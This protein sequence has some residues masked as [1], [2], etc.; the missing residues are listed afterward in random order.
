MLNYLN[1]TPR[2]RMGEWRFCST[3]LDVPYKEVSGK[4]SYGGL[5]VFSDVRVLYNLRISTLVTPQNPWP[6]CANSSEVY[7]SV[8]LEIVPQ[9]L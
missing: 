9:L 7:P 6:T 3:I 4:L 2:R 5:L 1:T 8:V